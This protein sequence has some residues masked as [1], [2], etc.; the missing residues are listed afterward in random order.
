VRTAFALLLSVGVLAAC[1]P[2]PEPEDGPVSIDTVCVRF[3]EAGGAEEV[4]DTPEPEE[5]V[6]PTAAGYREIAEGLVA[7]ARTT[8][9]RDGELDA[10]IDRLETGAE[11]VLADLPEEAS[12]E[13]AHEVAADMAEA[14][15]EIYFRC[16]Q[17]FQAT[18]PPG[19][20]RR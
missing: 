16:L 11:R 19:G 17:H 5:E 9:A 6:G 18:P 15:L 4:P 8:E 20:Y 14:S 1:G 12:D 3:T 7:F 10:V 2:D 13:E